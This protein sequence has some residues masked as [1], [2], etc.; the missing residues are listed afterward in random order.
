MQCRGTTCEHGS[1]VPDDQD[2]NTP[3]DQ[4]VAERSVAENT[5][6][7]GRSGLAGGG[8]DDDDLLMYSAATTR[9]L[10]GGQPDRSAR[11]VELDYETPESEYMVTLTATDPSGAY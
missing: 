7:Q 6:E 3:G 5:E 2:L 11:T 4:A 9:I 10:Q 8:E 1:G